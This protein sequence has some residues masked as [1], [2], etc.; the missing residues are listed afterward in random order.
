M[1]GLA[2]NIDCAHLPHIMMIHGTAL[3]PGEYPQGLARYKCRSH[4]IVMNNKES[5]DIFRAFLKGVPKWH[6]N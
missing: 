2:L 6:S 3:Q 1:I 4:T 5:D